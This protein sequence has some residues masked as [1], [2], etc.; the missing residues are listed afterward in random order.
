MTPS[1]A[2]LTLAARGPMAGCAPWWTSS[3]GGCMVLGRDGMKMEVLDGGEW[4]SPFTSLLVLVGKIGLLLILRR[5][6]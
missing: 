4:V 6:S 2:I 5:I 1:C 3:G